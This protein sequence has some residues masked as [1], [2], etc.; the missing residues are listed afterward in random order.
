LPVP[1][2][3]QQ[4]QLEEITADAVER[5]LGYGPGKPGDRMHLWNCL[6]SIAPQATRNNLVQVRD[7][8]FRLYAGQLAIRLA[9]GFQRGRMLLLAESGAAFAD[10]EAEAHAGEFLGWLEQWF[11]EA[12]E[13]AGTG[14]VSPTSVLMI[15]DLRNACITDLKLSLSA[16]VPFSHL[17]AA[18]L[19]FKPVSETT[20]QSLFNATHVW[21][22]LLSLAEE[23]DG[24]EQETERLSAELAT[25]I[26]PVAPCAYPERLISHLSAHFRRGAQCDF[27][28][29]ARLALSF[30][31]GSLWWETQP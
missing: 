13:A 27:A 4:R 28:P 10:R 7:R 18:I 8:I 30:Y 31:L 9:C 24:H 1:H 16:Y 15:R 22:S 25:G 23:A 20:Y 6:P 2:P 29:R 26:V 17:L 5:L 21:G 3:A 12:L 11:D 19:S 14:S